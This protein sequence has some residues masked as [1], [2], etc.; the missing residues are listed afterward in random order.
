MII[1]S[2]ECSATFCNNRVL[3]HAHRL[4]I[5]RTLKNKFLS[6]YLSIDQAL[7]TIDQLIDAIAL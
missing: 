6:S 3:I 2:N 5:L 1:S 4:G 7:D